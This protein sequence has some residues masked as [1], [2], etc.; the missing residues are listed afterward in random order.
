[1]IESYPEI[2]KNNSDE[3]KKIKFRIV[4]EEAM[5]FGKKNRKILKV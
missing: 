2:S 4:F 1:M 5:I 3:I